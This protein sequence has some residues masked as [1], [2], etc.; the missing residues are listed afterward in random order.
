LSRIIIEGER[1]KEVV[2]KLEDARRSMDELIDTLEMLQDEE[3]QMELKE[4]LS[5]AEKGEILSFGSVNEL[6]RA[7]ERST[8]SSNH[9]Q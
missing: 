9:E 7:L 4:S 2:T 3:F 8:E 6:E 1:L 5:E